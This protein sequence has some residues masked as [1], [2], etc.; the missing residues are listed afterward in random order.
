MAQRKIFIAGTALVLAEYN[1]SPLPAGILGKLMKYFGLLVLL[2]F[3]IQ[4]AVAFIRDIKFGKDVQDSDSCDGNEKRKASLRRGIIGIVIE[5]IILLYFG[6]LSIYYA[7][8]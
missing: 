2:L 4:A 7:L 5:I 6:I 1:M 3:F 8:H